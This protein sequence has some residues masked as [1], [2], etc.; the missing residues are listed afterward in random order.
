[1][2][3]KALLLVNFGGPRNLEEVTPFLIELLTDEELLRTNLPSFLHCFFFTRIAKKRASHLT[4]DY[5]EIGGFSPIYFDT[6]ELKKKLSMHLQQE[7]L[8]F[9]RYLPATHEESLKKI[10]VCKAKKI[11]VFPFFPQ[12]CSG[13]TGSIASFFCDRLS[14][15]ALAKLEWIRSYPDHPAFISCYQKKIGALMEKQG[16]SE[17]TTLLLFSFHGVPKAFIEEGDTYE[18][19]CL[20]SFN[21]C[22]KHF[23]KAAAFLSY[24]SKFGRGEWLEPATDTLCRRISTLAQGKTACIVV[25]ISFTSDHIET[26]FEI[27]KLYLPL[28]RAQGIK[29]FRCD[30][31]NCDPEWFYSI[32]Q[33]TK[34]NQKSFDTHSLCRW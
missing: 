12:F 5:E 8:T 1:M 3:D 32:L 24:Q 29:A 33:I 2:L 10:E 6:E 9:H 23:P 11:Q 21:A 16:L 27:E 18:K 31:L 13:T 20:A 4:K 17:E 26:L 22:R 7:V 15:K 19:E 28:I 34:E 25:P 14:P 30:A